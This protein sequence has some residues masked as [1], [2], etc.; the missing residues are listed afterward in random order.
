[1]KQLMTSDKG[2]SLLDIGVTKKISTISKVDALNKIILNNPDV[3]ISPKNSMLFKNIGNKRIVTIV[4]SGRGDQVA[5]RALKLRTALKKIGRLDDVQIVAVMAG[6]TSPLGGLVHKLPDIIGFDRL[7]RDAYIAT[8]RISDTIIGSSGTSSLFESLGLPSKLILHPAQNALRDLE[9]KLISK[10]G[11]IPNML[12]KDFPGDSKKALERMTHVDLDW[13]NKGNKILA[14]KYK[15]V[16]MAQTPE[17]WIKVIFDDKVSEK[18]LVIRSRQL[19]RNMSKG[20]G[21]LRKT[22]LPRL[23]R[24]AKRMK[25]L[26]GAGLLGLA[27]LPI[28]YSVHKLIDILRDKKEKRNEQDSLLP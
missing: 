24:N 19:L 16:S 4:G 5:Y 28:G 25:T 14:S 12:W 13:W 11:T 7:P 6:G 3:A 18:D 9:F 17:E 1:M 26:R 8:Q 10:P 20:A 21:K 15:G 2:P 27:S 22:H 23:I